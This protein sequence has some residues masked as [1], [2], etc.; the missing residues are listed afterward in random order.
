[1]KNTMEKLMRISIW[2]T[3]TI[4]ILRCFPSMKE[5]FGLWNE[6]AF[7]KLVYTLFGYIG[8][9]IGIGFVLIKIFDLWAWKYLSKIHGIPV[10]AQTYEGEISSSYDKSKTYKGILTIKQ[11]FTKISVKFKSDESSSFSVAAVI[12]DNY[13]VNQLIYTYQNNPNAIIQERSPIHHGTAILNIDNVNKIEGNYFTERV[14]V[15]YMKFNAIKKNKA[16]CKKHLSS[17]QNPFTTIF[18]TNR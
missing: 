10:L 13:D 17:K 11:T 3:I 14:F 9:A 16:G 4:F 18:T 12:M 1:M 6:G 15:G 7:W 2:T 5:L 8:E